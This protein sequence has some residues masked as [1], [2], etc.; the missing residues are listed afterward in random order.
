VRV[1]IY[2]TAAFVV[3]AAIALQPGV[4]GSADLQAGRADVDPPSSRVQPAASPSNLDAFMAKVLARRDVNRATLKQ[5]ILDESEGFEILGP[6]RSPLLRMK[7]DFTWYVRDGMHVRSPVRFDGVVVDAKSREEYEQSWIRREKER[8][9]RKAKNQR[10]KGEISIGSQGVQVQVGGAAVVPSEP[11][12]VSEAYF[13][14]FKFEPGNYYLAGREKLEGQDVLRIEYYP[15]NLFNDDDDEKTPR[16]MKRRG[17]KEQR[18][19]KAEEDINRKMNKTALV[20][21]WVDPTEHQI[22][23]YTFDNVWMDFLPAAWLVRVDDLRASMTMGQ[24]FPGVW[25]PR[26]M[27]IHAGVTLANG[28]YEAGYTRS[29]ADYREATVKST[30]RIPKEPR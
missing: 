30:I 4:H 23:K 21:L 16:E 10:E 6:G 7:K 27:N 29:F 25:L 3:A 11:R 17:R 26:G 22:V 24:P 1:P 2:V 28:S 5:Y 9:E 19:R 13:M 20:T 15:T 18:E 14:D 8:L 12:F